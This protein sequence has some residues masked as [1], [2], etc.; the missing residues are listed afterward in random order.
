MPRNINFGDNGDIAVLSVFY[1]FLYLLLSI[2]SAIRF[3]VELMGFI[4]EQMSDKR[5]FTH[6]TYLSKARVFFYFNAPTLVVG[7]MPMEFI[8]VVQSEYINIL[9]D[10]IY[11][12]EM[13]THIKVHTAISKARGIVYYYGWKN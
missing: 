10:E 3:A 4:F 5:F 12:K 8:E 2:V 7:E 11:S 1:N 9:L 13:A 6:R